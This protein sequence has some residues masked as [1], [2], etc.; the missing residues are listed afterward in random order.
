[1]LLKMPSTPATIL[2]PD[3]SVAAKATSMFTPQEAEIFRAYKKLLERH[4][5]MEALFCKTCGHASREDG[6]KAYVQDGQILVD[7][8]CTSRLYLGQSF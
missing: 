4:G 6:C 3:G 1:M 2:A 5:L 8:R 7:C